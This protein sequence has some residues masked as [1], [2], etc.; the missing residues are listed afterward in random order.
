MH[1]QAYR[2]GRCVVKVYAYEVKGC[3]LLIHIRL[4][5]LFQGFIHSHLSSSV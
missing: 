3:R 5:I 2:P 1:W 4:G